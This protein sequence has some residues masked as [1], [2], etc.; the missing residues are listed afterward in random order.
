[1]LNSNWH[2]NNLPLDTTLDGSS[3]GID[4]GAGEWLNFYSVPSGTN[5]YM[6]LDNNANGT[7]LLVKQN[8]VIKAPHK[9]V[10]LW[11]DTALAGE[12]LTIIQGSGNQEIINPAN[13][14]FD[15]LGSYG[16][17][18]LVQLDKIMNLYN[19]AITTIVQTISTTDV[20]LL[21]KTL[22]SDKIKVLLSINASNYQV[23]ENI[24]A[25]LDG[26]K[27][28]SIKNV[29]YN[30][31]SYIYHN[32]EFEVENVNGKVLAITGKSVSGVG[33]TA[34]LQEYTLKP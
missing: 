17:S 8:L 1:M 16:A 6:S 29:N 22:S 21:S 2:V 26:V 4:L 20:T 18:A 12:F 9:R 30:Y 33:V 14:T 11:S 28:A 7:K 32:F 13:T 27:I 15:E 19:N 10:Y 5:I 24:E 3:D 25:S 23:V 34:T 31:D